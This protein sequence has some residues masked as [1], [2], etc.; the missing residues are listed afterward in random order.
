M[1]KFRLWDEKD[2]LMIYESIDHCIN[3]DGHVSENHSELIEKE[4]VIMQFTG[5]VDK[6]GIEVYD[7]IYWIFM[8]N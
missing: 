1:K 8:K 7:V 6:N 5:L 3:I 2:K 4:F